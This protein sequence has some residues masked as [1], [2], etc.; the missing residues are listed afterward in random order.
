MILFNKLQGREYVH[1][2]KA[3]EKMMRKKYILIISIALLLVAGCSH[4]TNNPENKSE[5]VNVSNQKENESTE[6]N[7]IVD[8]KLKSVKYTGSYD[9]RFLG[10][11]DDKVYLFDANGQILNEYSNDNYP[12]EFFYTIYAKRYI[13]SAKQNAY[14]KIT[15]ING[16]DISY[17]YIKSD[18]KFYNIY[19]VDKSP[20]ILAT[21]F[22]EN[23]TSSV[24]KLVFKDVRGDIQYS[25]STDDE[26]LKSNKI[27][28][29]YFK[30]ST[31]KVDY[32]GDGIIYLKDMPYSYFIN[33]KTKEVFKDTYQAHSSYINGYMSYRSV[34][35]NGILD[36]HGNQVLGSTSK[37]L[38]CT[39]SNG[40][41]YNY[42]DK[43]YYG[44][45]NKNG[46]WIKE[47]QSTEIRY[48]KELYE[49]VILYE[50]NEG[51]KVYD[52]KSKKDIGITMT[53]TNQTFVKD[54]FF[55]ENYID[56]KD[57][58]IYLYNFKENKSKILELF[59]L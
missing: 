55:K 32:I 24:A 43:K 26:S 29:K 37:A 10:T 51:Y 56:I 3:K 49:D 22:E 27:D 9:N 48:K 31:L 46:E 40:V 36:V 30:S 53:S 44:I 34:S 4:K 58:K 12:T 38:D 14:Y 13:N 54:N 6:I 28:V 20:M 25:V 42:K 2:L 23:P 17:K 47:L 57:G 1:T 21:I 8:V 33:I 16:N 59:K 18:D 19:L 7:N 5:N 15:D 45:I 11:S 50:D 39:Y 52:I 35:G 41:Y